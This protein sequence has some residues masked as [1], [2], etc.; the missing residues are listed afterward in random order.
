MWVALCFLPWSPEIHSL[1]GHR[2][3][4][5][6]PM[7]TRPLA[8]A[9]SPP[10]RAPSPPPTGLSGVV[11]PSPRLTPLPGKMVP[12]YLVGFSGGIQVEMSVSLS[13]IW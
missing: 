2:A 10:P 3:V 7:L 1:S 9:L 12:A 5:V 11:W 13:L 8:T 6:L 4:Q